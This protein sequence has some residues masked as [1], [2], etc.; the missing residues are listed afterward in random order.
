M[1]AIE[2]DAD[3]CDAIEMDADLCGILDAAVVATTAAANKRALEVATGGPSDAGPDAAMSLID[4]DDSDL[5]LGV[6]A[7][8]P[9]PPPPLEAG[10]GVVNCPAENIANRGLGK[11]GRKV[12]AAKKHKKG[13]K[14]KKH[15]KDKKDKKDKN[16][17]QD[18]QQPAPS[19]AGGSGGN[20]AAKDKKDKKDKQDKQQPA[21]SDAGGS[22][23]NTAASGASVVAP[24]VWGASQGSTP[25]AGRDQG[26][27]SVSSAASGATVAAP[28]VHAPL[29]G[30]PA[31]GA[32]QASQPPACTPSEWGKQ[33]YTAEYNRCLSTMACSSWARNP[34]CRCLH[35]YGAR[36]VAKEHAQIAKAEAV[37]EFKKTFRNAA[38]RIVGS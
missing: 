19:D 25:P 38:S 26:A 17:K 6:P 34:R 4:C 11:F 21:P 8:W 12:C 37:A 14:D 3:L 15:K 10:D 28:G 18:K 24:A 23:G 13:K 35:C 31:W 9:S 22:G 5:L 20:T 36:G 16:D 29:G 1:D 30:V 32:S 33:V 27:A 2:I 7:P